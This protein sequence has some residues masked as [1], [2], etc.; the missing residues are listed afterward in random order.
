MSGEH[1]A[2]LASFLLACCAA[3]S[4]EQHTIP[5]LVAASP[6]GD[7]QGVLR[8]AN[9]ADA[10]ATVTIDDAD[11]GPQ[12][13]TDSFTDSRGRTARYRLQFGGGWDLT[14][15]RGL[16]IYFHGNNTGTEQQMLDW[17][18]DNS[19]ALERGLLYAVVASPGTTSSDSPEA[20]FFGAGTDEGGVR[21]WS[22]ARDS[23]LVHELLQSD[24]GGNAAVDRD[25]VVFRGSSQGACFLNE[26]LARYGHVYGGGFHAHCGCIWSGHGGQSPPRIANPWMPTAPWT[27]HV[28][29]EAAKRMRVFVEATTGDFLHDDA[30]ATR[31]YYRDLIGLETRWDLDAPGGHCSAGATPRSS[32]LEWL[33]A[34]VP[35]PRIFGSIAGDHDGDGLADAADPDDDNDGALDIVDDLP[36]EF[37]EWLDLDGD[38]DGD[39]LDS[40]ADGDGVGNASDPFPLD[41][42]EWADADADGIGDNIDV[43]DDNDGVADTAGAAPAQ[44]M[45][46]GQLSFIFNGGADVRDPYGPKVARKHAAR[47]AGVAYPAPA[48]DIRTYHSIRLG[49]S[50]NP[51]F[52]IVVDSHERDEACRELLR[53]EFCEHDITEP[54]HVDFHYERWLHE[55]RID[56]N[57]NLDLTD[58]GPPLVFARSDG[59]VFDDK[60]WGTAPGVN[61]VLNVR[62]AT[63]EVLP[64]ALSLNTLHNPYGPGAREGIV[65]GPGDILLRYEGWSGWRGHVP[66]PGGDPVLVG[67][68]DANWDGIFN[69]GT[70]EFDDLQAR[71]QRTSDLREVQDWAGVDDLNDRTYGGPDGQTDGDYDNFRDFACVDTDRDG[72]LAEC[73]DSPHHLGA[74]FTPFYPGEP[75]MLDGVGCTLDIPPTGHTARIDCADTS[76]SFSGSQANLTFTEDSP[77]SAVTLPAAT[78]GNGTLTYSLSPSVPGLTFTASNRRLSGTPTAPGTYSM[79]YTA[80]DDD[81]T[82]TLSFTITV[83][84][85]DP[86][87]SGDCR[88][89]LLVNPGESCFD[90]AADTTFTVRSDGTAQYGTTYSGHNITTNEFKA[91][92]QESDVWRIDE[93]TGGAPNTAPRFSGA[94]FPLEIWYRGDTVIIPLTLP[95]AAG[96]VPP[97][98][99]SLEIYLASGGYWELPPPR[100]S[101]VPGLTFDSETR[102][103]S[104]TPRTHF[105]DEPISEHYIDSYLLQYSATDSNGSTARLQFG[106]NVADADRFSIAHGREVGIQYCDGST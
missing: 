49:D 16:L 65:V 46:G 47:P 72:R 64:Y 25:R 59:R 6:G 79:A 66:A 81:G 42:G 82:G 10:A 24:F 22:S 21:A 50:A 101:L 103:L 39:F 104:G 94:C 86:R 61:T 53:A 90:R 95:A 92:Y 7:P 76:P 23:R 83:N 37:R 18:G 68:V 17:F 69:S 106:I 1:R 5:L 8:L 58:D 30:V 36:F 41:P 74:S 26:F 44:G 87:P 55:V 80:T 70:W 13:L 96:G 84:A 51:V 89:G 98:A 9:D 43:D 20:T 19:D 45:G 60:H 52:E 35:V 31:D 63:G 38:G 40:D 29:S 12:F 88:V 100:P 97:L 54:R 2:T 33:T 32:I 91:T 77:I 105:N 56:R 34:G 15:P 4:A 71:L 14:R 48:G 75:F 99:Y 73:G 27:D 28:S 78:G 62:Y 93:V 102:R 3:A 57:Q 85:A 67:T 11:G